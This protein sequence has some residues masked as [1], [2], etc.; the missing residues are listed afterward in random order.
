MTAI[1]RNPWVALLL[2]LAF[3]GASHAAK[4][5][6]DASVVASGFDVPTQAQDGAGEGAQASNALTFEGDTGHDLFVSAGA[7]SR[8]GAVSA[9]ANARG[10]LA[11][12]AHGSAYGEWADSFSMASAG[13]TNQRWGTMTVSVALSGSMTGSFEDIA[14]ATSYV[15]ARMGLNSGGSFHQGNGWVEN[16]GAHFIGIDVPERSTG[17]QEFVLTMDIDFVWGTNVSM[18][19]QLRATAGIVVFDQPDGDSSYANATSQYAHTMTWLGISHVRDEAG[20]AVSHFTAVSADTG[21]NYANAVA[22]PEPGELWL[23]TA[24]LFVLR[25]RSGRPRRGCIS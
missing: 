15:T 20:Q 4:S 23:V 9:Y 11:T 17:D 22:V 10:D 24:G 13:M 14:Y 2:G 6:A 1:K 3:M 12:S 8:A 16:G 18:Y 19:M 5:H 25:W 7:T 21:I